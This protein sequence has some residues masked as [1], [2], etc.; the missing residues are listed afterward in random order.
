[1][2]RITRLFREGRS[3]YSKVREVTRVVDVV[4]EQRLCELALTA[5]ASHAVRR[6]RGNIPGSLKRKPLRGHPAADL[7]TQHRGV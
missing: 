2:P 4:D 6:C 1:M 7:T 5:T 3:S